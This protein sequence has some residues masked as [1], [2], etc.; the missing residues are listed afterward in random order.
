MDNE[1]LKTSNWQD[2]LDS[3]EYDMYTLEQAT[4]R[5]LERAK[6]DPVALRDPQALESLERVYM[7]LANLSEIISMRAPT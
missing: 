7:R 3:A 1:V 6:S 4:D 5:A 2:T